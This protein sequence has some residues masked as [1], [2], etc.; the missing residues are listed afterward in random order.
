MDVRLPNGKVI[1]GVPEGTPKEQ[2][3]QKAISA[4]LATQADF[5]TQPMQEQPPA[6]QPQA[7]TTQPVSQEDPYFLPTEEGY[8]Q[9]V[10]EAP[11]GRKGVSDFTAA[12]NAI[13]AGET[14]LSTITGGT[15][16]M[17][18]GALGGL[19]GAIG[20]LAGILTPEEAQA[21]QQRAAATFTYEPKTEA[22]QAQVRAIG[23]A[24]QSLPPVATGLPNAGR[25]RIGRQ[26]SKVAVPEQIA[27]AERF[28]EQNRAPLFASDVAPPST[29]AGKAVRGAA[30]KV[31]FVGTGGMRAKQQEA[32]QAAISGFTEGFNQ[33]T[34]QDLYNSLARSQDKVSKAM[35]KR[36]E[37][38]GNKMGDAP[39]PAT[40]TIAAIDSEIERMNKPG[41][42][43]DDALLSQLNTLKE[44]ISSG[45]VDYNTMRNNRTYVRESLKSET[46][47]TQSDRVIDRVYKAMTDDIH[48]AVDSVAGPQAVQKLKAVDARL[49]KQYNEAKKTK[50][51]NVLSKGDVKP[52]EVS[53]MLMS[54]D[55]SENVKLYRE[56]DSQGRDNARGMLVNELAKAFEDNESPERFLQ[57]AKKLENQ[58]DVFMKGEQKHAYLDL[59][60]YLKQT[61]QAAQSGIYNQ[62]G[63]QIM[64]LIS[65]APVADI[66][67]TGGVATAGAITLGTAGRLLES[68]KLR[69]ALR[70]IKQSRPYTPEYNQALIGLDNAVN[71]LS[72][73]NQDQ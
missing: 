28:A 47:K 13:G 30:E 44:Q 7:G 10:P 43:A 35:S 55:R 5:Q 72:A 19:A 69:N 20:D 39:V 65:M 26:P 66:A 50:L 62:N 9:P 4:G 11:G 2:I 58:M 45:D 52:E 38:I 3:M 71:E 21:L 54:N 64:T 37:E 40:K 32:R 31:P 73:E 15:T 61:K 59:L 46:A 14:A 24:T 8:S 25:V 27:R 56:L 49:A 1:K 18:A 34:D 33:V 36:Y 51:K 42:I 70:K 57:R 12:E 60:S 68:R 41:V 67:G 23:E 17:A 22:G 63:Q 6:E 53:K 16:G 48:S 29:F